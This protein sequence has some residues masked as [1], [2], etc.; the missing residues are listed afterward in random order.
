MNFLDVEV[1]DVQGTEAKGAHAAIDPVV[2]NTKGRPI[3]KGDRAVMGLRPQYMSADGAGSGRVEGKVV[4][5]ERL[6]SETVADL[7]LR[8][9]T[10]LIATFSEDRVLPA[11]QAVALRFDPAEAH[12]FPVGG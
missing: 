2:L 10:H 7:V 1:M 8:D 4:V 3:A 11:D 12:L 9:G 5:A 6:G